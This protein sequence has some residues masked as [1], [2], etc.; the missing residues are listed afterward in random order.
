M[1]SIFYFF[2]CRSKVSLAD[3]NGIDEE[4]TNSS[5][6]F[7]SLGVDDWLVD[8]LAAMS[9]KRPTPIQAACIRPILEGTYPVFMIEVNRQDEIA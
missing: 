4:H 5:T 1:S 9:I 6:A 2:C 7:S 3:D 8:A